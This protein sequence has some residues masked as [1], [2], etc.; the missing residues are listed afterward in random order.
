MIKESFKSSSVKA[1]TEELFPKLTDGG[2]AGV[3]YYLE[4]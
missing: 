1:G 4:K 3:T 2:I